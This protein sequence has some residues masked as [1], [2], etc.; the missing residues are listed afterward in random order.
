MSPIVPLRP[1]TPRQ[2]QA[3]Y[4][5]RD[6][7]RI[8]G[9][10]PSEAEIA[11]FLK[12]SPPAAHEL[13]KQLEEAGRV[14]RRPG[15]ARSLGV[16]DQSAQQER[17][18]KGIVLLSFRN[19]PIENI[20]AGRLCPECSSRQGYSRITDDEMKLLMKTAVNRV[21][22]LLK[23]REEDPGEYERLLQFASLQTKRW[24]SP[25]WSTDL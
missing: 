3:L 22:T 7:S 11:R 13:V 14:T 20:H 12:V 10:S 17:E 19:G 4:F 5:V 18:A 9:Q 8:H 23:L 15:E 24:D 1:V 6:Y 21:F 25:E 16:A 2:A